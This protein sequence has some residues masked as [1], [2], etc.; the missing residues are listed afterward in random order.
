MVEKCSGNGIRRVEL[1]N[2]FKIRCLLIHHL[3]RSR[4]RL[5]NSAIA[6]L[7]RLD[8][9]RCVFYDT[10]PAWESRRSRQNAPRMRCLTMWLVAIHWRRGI[11]NLRSENIKSIFVLYAR[12]EPT[13][14]SER[15]SCC[16]ARRAIRLAF[17]WAGVFEN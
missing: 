9:G 8:L 12:N 3:L 1:P 16:R 5:R 14:G 17:S 6:A 2:R 13:Q 15:V 11:V 7:E 10:L 4:S